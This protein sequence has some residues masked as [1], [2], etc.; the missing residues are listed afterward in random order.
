MVNIDT[1]AETMRLGY[2]LSPSAQVEALSPNVALTGLQKGSTFS[3]SAVVDPPR[4][5]V[6]VGQNKVIDLNDGR[7]TSL[8]VP[9][10]NCGG[11]GGVVRVTGIRIYAIS[12]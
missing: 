6:Y 10:F 3:L 5:A 4:Y 2:F 1:A 12:S 11:Q 7:N 9:G 8:G